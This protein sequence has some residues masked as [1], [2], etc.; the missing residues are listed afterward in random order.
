M[1]P[2]RHRAGKMF[3]ERLPR[4]V[5]GQSLFLEPASYQIGGGQ[6]DGVSTGKMLGLQRSQQRV[7][8]PHTPAGIIFHGRGWNDKPFPARGLPLL[9]FPASE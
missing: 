1:Y 9:G 7:D 6:V 2:H 5:R 4:E 8:A 3:E